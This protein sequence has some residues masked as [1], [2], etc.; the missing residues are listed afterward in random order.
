[1]KKTAKL[2]ICALAVVMSSVM[3]L[4]VFATDFDTAGFD[5]YY[6]SENAPQGT[7][8]V[9]IL[10]R[11]DMD[12]ENYTD[13]NVGLN[14]EIGQDKSGSTVMGE[15]DI[16]SESEI[17]T[18][19]EDGYVSLSFHHKQMEY[20]RIEEGRIY[21]NLN[22]EYDMVSACK[23][24]KKFKA[25]YVDSKGNVLGVTN[26]VRVRP[27][28]HTWYRFYL[29]G[30]TLK[31]DN[32]IAGVNIGIVTFVIFAVTILIL[33]LGILMLYFIVS[34]T[35]RKIREKKNKQNT[36]SEV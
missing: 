21:A 27:T 14:I 19:D 26:A 11:I 2:L 28:D 22:T 12:D 5:T 1:M 33:I 8:Y 6:I 7:V 34:V 15:L 30:D 20:V 16:T 25:A 24:Y 32:M 3:T 23:D 4:D 36:S 17:V 10:A 18:F 9:D 31:S 13:F 35:K 29:D